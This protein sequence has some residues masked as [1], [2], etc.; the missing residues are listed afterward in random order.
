[1]S[2]SVEQQPENPEPEK[3]ADRPTPLVRLTVYGTEAALLVALVSPV[4][5]LPHG[6]PHDKPHTDNQSPSTRV[7]DLS[8]MGAASTS[9]GSSR[10]SNFDDWFT[11][12]G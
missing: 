10:L 5:D 1:M 9:V 6:I 4:H 8:R 11:K 12:R 7:D 3:D 2:Y